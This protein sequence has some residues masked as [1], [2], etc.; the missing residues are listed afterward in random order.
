MSTAPLDTSQFKDRY[1]EA[2]LEIIKARIEGS[3][4]VV[5]Q[6]VEVAQ[7]LNFMEALRSSLAAAE[8][9]TGKKKVTRK[10]PPAKSVAASRKKKKKA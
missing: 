1:Q 9:D 2:L 10:K 3:A 7:S 8:A 6:E 4:P 5:A